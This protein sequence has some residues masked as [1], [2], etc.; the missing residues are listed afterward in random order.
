MG[1]I[2]DILLTEEQKDRFNR[3]VSRGVSSVTAKDIATRIL[4]AQRK[5]L[6][7]LQNQPSV[8]PERV[9][10]TNTKTPIPAEKGKRLTNEQIQ[11]QRQ[12]AKEKETIKSRDTGRFQINHLVFTIPPEQIHIQKDIKNVAMAVLRAPASQRVRTG[13][14]FVQINVPLVFDTLT[15]VNNRLVPL[16]KM[17]RRYPFFYVE[18]KFLR[19]NLMPD[20]PPEQAMYFVLQSLTVQSVENLP[21]TFQL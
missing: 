13:H 14:G 6:G 11:E 19:K 18:N 12:K 20:A 2:D 1:K 21:T 8:V 17:A 4:P 7:A 9:S 10:G 15:D 5:Q 16:I 3:L